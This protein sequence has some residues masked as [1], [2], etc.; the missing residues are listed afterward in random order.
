ERDVGEAAVDRALFAG[1]EEP[2]VVSRPRSA[3][4]EPLPRTRLDTEREAEL[5]GSLR[6]LDH[7]LGP[8]SATPLAGAARIG[9]ELEPG[10]GPGEPG[11][12]QL[13]RRQRCLREDAGHSPAV[14]TL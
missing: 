3:A 2:G 1:D 14:A 9:G 13:D 6:Q 11:F 10:E 4:R 8:E 12:V 5:V 7:R